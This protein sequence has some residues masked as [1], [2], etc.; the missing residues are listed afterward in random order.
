[1]II[2]E[3]KRCRTIVANLL[4]FARLKS[5]NLRKENLN[6]II[7]RSLVLLKRQPEYGG[8]L[9]DLDL[10]P[11]M[12]ELRCDADQI[13]QVVMNLV[14]NAADAMGGRGRVGITTRITGNGSY[15]EMEITDQGP[16]VPPEIRKTI[17]EPFFSTKR[18]KGIGL[19]LS[20]VQTIVQQ[21]QGSIAVGSGPDCKGAKF[22]VRFPMARKE[23]ITTEF[24]TET[25][26]QRG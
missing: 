12:P 22:S 26:S 23:E 24:S 16:G 14:I 21:H 4:D 11:K 7:E 1:M 15:L 9:L 6:H 5:H 17:F 20:V 2:R 19:G 25:A 3:A 8:L 18:V 10:W 13:Q